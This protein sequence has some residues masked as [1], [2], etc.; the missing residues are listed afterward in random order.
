MMSV[1]VLAQQS[2]DLRQA[3]HLRC[4]QAPSLP[5]EGASLFT[6]STGREN[7]NPAN[8]TNRGP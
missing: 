2:P 4:K 8:E 6:G 1:S 3:Q 7:A 5:N